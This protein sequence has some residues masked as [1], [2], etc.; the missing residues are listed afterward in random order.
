MEEKPSVTSLAPGTFL[1]GV[2][3][4]RETVYVAGPPTDRWAFWQGH[5]FHL[6]LVSL[7]TG[8]IRPPGA[9]RRTP[10]PQSLSA[11]MPATVIRV[12]VAAG[13]RV[14]KGDTVVLLEA[15]KMELPIRTL[16][17]GTIAAVRCHEGELVRADQI[18]IE[19][20]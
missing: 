6:D 3:D 8:P 10:V 15:M 20:E 5:V 16:S 12:L 1:V 14:K 11:P 2:G 4:R 9:V 17:D 7:A 19:I 13:S 18:L